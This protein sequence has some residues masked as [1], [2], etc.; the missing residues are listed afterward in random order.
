MNKTL[1]LAGVAACFFAANAN[2][3]DFHQ[4]V[5]VKGTY[6]DMSNEAK[7]V[8]PEDE[9]E[10][11]G[12]VK[13][14]DEVFGASFAYGVKTGPVRTELEL[15]WHDDAESKDDGDKFKVENNSIM[16]NA[17]YDIETG[18][19]FTPY[20]GAGL[21]M[22]RLK[23]KGADVSESSNE[24]VWQ[25]GLGVSYAAT[26]NVSVDLGYRYVDNGS[27]SWTD[28]AE[29]IKFSSDSNEFYLGVRYAF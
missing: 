7:W 6:N 17:Y 10:P 25:L 14:D 23:L 29:R 21:G 16:L 12:K 1:L 11:T 20:V 19:K 8:D 2:A 22:A 4:Y 24:F 5:S 28:G 3:L 9:E 13:L 15:N 26:D 27:F 18:T